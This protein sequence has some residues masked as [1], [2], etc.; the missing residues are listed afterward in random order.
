M[1]IHSNINM[2]KYVYSFSKSNFNSMCNYCNNARAYIINIA[3][4]NSMCI[5][6]TVY[7]NKQNI[8]VFIP[9]SIC[10]GI[11]MT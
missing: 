2:T 11:H 8:C 1:C 7:D 9:I 10:V 5:R 4:N 6:M 3:P